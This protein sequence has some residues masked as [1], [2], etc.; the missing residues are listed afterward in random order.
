LKRIVTLCIASLGVTGCVRYSTLPLDPGRELNQLSTR[1]VAMIESEEY[2]LPVGPFDASDGLDERELVAIALRFNTDLA[3]A[4]AATGEANAGLLAAGVLPDPELGASLQPGVGGTDSFNADI[5]L[6]FELLRVGE[7]RAR[8]DVARAGAA[9]ARASVA[10]K[11]YELATEV[12]RQLTIV[13]AAEQQLALL[14]QELSLRRQSMELVQRR[15]GIGEANA[16]DAATAQLELIEIERD[17]R[18]AAAELP[19]ERAELNRLLGLPAGYGLPL[20]DSGKPLAIRLVD[21]PAASALRASM[22]A[23][24]LD[25]AAKA[26]EYRKAEDELRLEVLRQYPSLKVGPAFSHEGPSDNYLGI[27]VALDVPLLN[28]NRGEI[29]AKLAQRDRVRA[30]YVDRL[31]QLAADADIAATRV[32][33]LRAEVDAQREAL[34]PLL[35]QNE[36]LYRSAL[37]ARELNIVDFVTLQQRALQARRSHL[38]TLADYRIALIELDGSA[39]LTLTGLLP[40]KAAT[41]K[42]IPSTQETP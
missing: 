3:V 26:A 4:R 11:E 39:G 40:P 41:Q 38:K 18:Q 16:L 14:D 7:R 15:R 25:L 34:L 21:V 30:E 20:A 36:R 33:S 5:D 22:L 10:A 35:E 24:R 9:V 37:D 23:G 8:Q 17:R 32:V 19:A 12:R 13:L 1:S 28:R 27:G 42:V 2:P 31:H 29:A 6:M